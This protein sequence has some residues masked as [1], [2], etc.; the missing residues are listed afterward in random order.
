MHFQN[1]LTDL[2]R[3]AEKFLK[4]ASKY[5]EVIIITNS[6]EG[7][8]NYSADKYCPYL[9]SVVKNY[10]VVSAR[11]RY[12]RF[13]PGQPL[14]WKAAAFAHEVNELY[15]SLRDGDECA[16]LE[17]TDVSSTSSQ[18]STID[19]EEDPILSGRE[20]VSVG[21]SLEERTAVRIV[22]E[23]LDATSKSVKFLHAPT[24]MQLMG[25]LHM[26]TN[27]MKHVCEHK[28]TLD[29]EIGTGQADYAASEYLQVNDLSYDRSVLAG[30]TM[31]EPSGAKH[32]KGTNQVVH[33]SASS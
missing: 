6:D 4:E 26:L 27:H 3:C 18:E 19:S 10:R 21:D 9:L 16:S 12:E 5:G 29:L 24:P 7:W 1:L 32:R 28:E 15:E 2:G 14:C 13:Y 30:M 23:Q 25:Q 8:V 22:A 20:I 11:T 17:G 33:A 31:P